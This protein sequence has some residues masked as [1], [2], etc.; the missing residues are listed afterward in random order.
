M[1][2]RS[3]ISRSIPAACSFAYRAAF[4]IAPLHY[5]TQQRR[6]T[7]RGPRCQKASGA[8]VCLWL[9]KS[10]EGLS[11]AVLGLKGKPYISEGRQQ[12]CA[13]WRPSFVPASRRVRR[14]CVVFYG[15]WASGVVQESCGLGVQPD[16]GARTAAERAPGIAQRHASSVLEASG[17]RLGRHGEESLLF[18]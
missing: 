16:A 4:L 3:S 6:A 10:A 7:Q 15:I 18:F 17:Q 8:S 5:P 11:D 14:A 9:R 13:V 1:S 2:T 12:L